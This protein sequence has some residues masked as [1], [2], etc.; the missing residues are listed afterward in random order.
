MLRTEG[1]FNRF[2]TWRNSG[3]GRFTPYCRDDRHRSVRVQLSMSV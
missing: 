3:F 2:Y 1:G